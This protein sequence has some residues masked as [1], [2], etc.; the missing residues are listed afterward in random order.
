MGELDLEKQKQVNIISLKVFYL[1]SFF[2][3][4]S[5]TPLLSV[6]LANEAGLSGIET[7]VG[8]CM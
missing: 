8:D 5:L 1:F 4:G 2:A 3:V 6:Y 7:F